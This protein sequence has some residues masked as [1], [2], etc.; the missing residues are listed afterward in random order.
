MRWGAVSQLGGNSFHAHDELKAIGSGVNN[1]SSLGGNREA[2]L[3]G[4]VAQKF[5]S[6]EFGVICHHLGFCLARL[7]TGSLCGNEE[8][9]IFAAGWLGNRHSRT[10]GDLH[11]RLRGPRTR[12]G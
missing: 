7:N 1:G 8:W 5:A 2:R 4:A 9:R 12:E 10:A 3:A 6:Y 11:R